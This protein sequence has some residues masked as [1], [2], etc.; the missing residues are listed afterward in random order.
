MDCEL[1]EVQGRANWAPKHNR[2]DDCLTTLRYRDDE[3]DYYTERLYKAV[4]L[5]QV[6][7][8]NEH[9][10]KVIAPFLSNERQTTISDLRSW[11]KKGF[12]LKSDLQNFCQ[13][14][15][16][17]LTF[18]PEIELDPH[19]ESKCINV[20]SDEKIIE[21]QRSETASSNAKQVVDLIDT[22]SS[23]PINGIGTSTKNIA[24]DLQSKSE[25]KSPV[26]RSFTRKVTYIAASE[27]EEKSGRKTNEHEVMQLLKEWA[28]SGRYSQ[29]VSESKNGVMWF[30]S[31]KA[32][33]QEYD[34]DACRKALKAWRD[35]GSFKPDPIS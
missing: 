21:P 12:L 29:L 34:L 27:I 19:N 13:R 6:D 17:E 15:R 33:P 22:N 10:D 11:I 1:F 26:A 2:P 4:S 32:K 8:W 25:S 3:I 30:A 20:A 9:L 35:A 31:G 18:I 7:I 28:R 5:G 23:I 14:E 24:K 16:I